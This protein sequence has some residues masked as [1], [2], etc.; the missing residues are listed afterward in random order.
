MDHQEQ[1]SNSVSV[2][3]KANGSVHSAKVC[4][5]GMARADPVPHQRLSRRL[6]LIAETI[7][8]SMHDANVQHIVQI[9]YIRIFLSDGV[10]VRILHHDA[11]IGSY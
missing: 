11:Q 5:F 9:S 6:P 1:E 8:C 4:D 7:Y 2:K 3:C 10:E